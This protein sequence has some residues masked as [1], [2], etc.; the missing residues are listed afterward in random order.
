MK[1]RILII[2]D[3]VNYGLMIKIN[4]EQTGEFEAD[5]AT[6]AIA[7]YEKIRA[8]AYDLIFLD[9][10]M[11][12]IEG[13]VALVEIKKMCQTPVV[14]MSAYVPPLQKQAIL[15]AGAQACLEKPVPLER[16]LKLIHEIT[17]HPS[18]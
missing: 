16:L 11:P 15:N 18:A 8:Q 4:L 10:L 2:D 5:T 13:N 6:S 17:A 3:E 9:I 1:K 14:I 12:K 7:G